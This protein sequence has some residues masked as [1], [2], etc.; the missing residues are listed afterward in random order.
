LLVIVL[1]NYIYRPW[2]RPY[3][4][5]IEHQRYICNFITPWDLPLG[6]NSVIAALI[7]ISK[8]ICAEADTRRR[9]YAERLAAG[10]G[11]VHRGL[12]SGALQDLRYHLVH[13]LFRALLVIVDYEYYE[14]E[15]D[16]TTV[17]RVSL[18]LIRTGIEDRLSA[19]ISLGS[20]ADKI[21]GYKGEAQAVVNTTL[22]TAIDFIMGLE[23]RELATSGSQFLM[24]DG[25]DASGDFSRW[26]K[27]QPWEDEPFTG[28][29][30][31]FGNT[32]E[33]P[34][35]LGAGKHSDSFIMRKHE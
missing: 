11:E 20:I 26:W 30:S 28:P 21:D 27:E 33:Y 8:A 34:E 15:D 17:G 5:D 22:E 23:Q 19:P 29:N 10:D 1:R 3:R 18:S 2:S 7:A 13:L 6:D 9:V 35:W 4:S 16:S 32:E 12:R 24:A 14:A 25:W 31:R